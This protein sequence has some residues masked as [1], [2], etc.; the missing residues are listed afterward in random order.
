MNRL[1]HVMFWALVVCSIPALEARAG[2]EPD[3]DGDGLADALEDT[4]GN[5]LF[6]PGETDLHNADTDGGGTGDGLERA[7]G[8]DPL[9]TLDDGDAD[10]D[11]DGLISRVEWVLG[12]ATL[13][14]D[15]DHDGLA[16]GLEVGERG[17]TDPT[18]VTNPLV[19]DTDLDGLL[20]GDEDADRDG[21]VDADESDPNRAD[22]DGGGTSD[23]AERVGGTDPQDPDDDPDGDPDGDGLLNG[24]ERARGTNPRAADTDADGFNDG[25]EVQVSG[26]NPRLADTDGDGLDDAVEDTDRDGHL[27]AN[28]TDPRLADTDGGGSGDGEER[29][30]G[31]NPR[32]GGDDPAGDLDGDSLTA[33]TERA[34]GTDPNDDDTDDDGLND[35]AEVSGGTAPLLADTDA[36]GLVDGLEDA[37]R[38]GRTDVGESDP[39][40]ADS[41][42]GGTP[43]GREVTDST[44]PLE[45]RD[46][47]ERDLDDDGLPAR[48]ELMLGTSPE[49]SDSDDDGVLDG[50]EPAP[51]EDSD[52]DGDVNALDFDSDNDT[53]PDGLELGVDLPEGG[54]DV[55][56]GHFTPDAEPATTTSPIRADTD[57]GGRSDGEEDINGNGRQDPGETSPNRAADDPVGAPDTDADGLS[58]AEERAVGTDPQDA[59]TDDDGLVDGAEAEP[60]VDSDGD[61]A[62]NA[63]DADSDDDG[64][65][66]G[67]EQGVTRRARGTEGERFTPDAEPESRT[68]PLRADTDGDGRTD[69]AEDADRDG[70]QGRDETDPN[71][72]D[73]DGDGLSDGLEFLGDTDGD[74][75][76]DGLDVDSDN[77]GTDDGVE[78]TNQ[79][80]RVDADETDPRRAEGPDPFEPDDDRRPSALADGGAETE[81]DAG[82]GIAE[83]GPDAFDGRGSQPSREPLNGSAPDSDGDGV[84]DDSE[85]SAGLNPFDADSDDD[86]LSDSEEGLDDTDGDGQLDALDV[87][88]DDDGLFDGTEAGRTRPV[89]GTSLAAGRFRAD[90]DPTDQTSPVLAD[91]DGG[92]APDGAEDLN[93]NGRV[94]PGETDPTQANDDSEAP[95][96][97]ANGPAEDPDSLRARGGGGRGCSV[98]APSPTR[99]PLGGA[100]LVALAAVGLRRRRLSVAGAAVL[101]VGLTPRIAAAYDANRF[102]PAAGTQAM[103]AVESAAVGDSLATRFS[104]LYHYARSPLVAEYP[105]GVMVG[106]LLQGLSVVDLTVGMAVFDR[107]ELGIGLPMGLGLS[108]QSGEILEG[109]RAQDPQGGALGDLR[110]VFGVALLPR[111][112]EGVGLAVGLEATAPTGNAS[113]W[114]GAP[115]ATWHP[116]MM[117]DAARGRLLLA[118]NAGWRVRPAEKLLGETVDDALSFAA[119]VRVDVGAGLSLGAE[120][121][122]ELP[123]SETDTSGIAADALGVV[124]WNFQSCF[125]LM[126]GGGRGLGSA[127]GNPTWRALGGL[128]WQCAGAAAP[129]PS[130][131]DQGN[132]VQHAEPA[133]SAPPAP[134]EDRDADGVPNERDACPEVAEDF[135]GFQ[136]HDGCPEPDNDNDRLADENDLCPNAAEDRDGVE[137]DDGCPDTDDDRD[138]ILDLNDRCPREPED[139]DGVED[140]DGCPDVEPT[141]VQAPVTRYGDA[142]IRGASIGL[143]RPIVLTRKGDR[144]PPSVRAQLADVA[145]LLAA[146]P[147]LAHV[148]IEVH[149]DSE[150]SDAANLE[151]TQLRARQILQLLVDLGVSPSRLKADGRGES[152]PIDSNTDP[153]GR[154]ANRR[155]E[156]RLD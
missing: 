145:A 82:S 68:N 110:G 56:A 31:S 53:L 29:R 50:R 26:T 103:T 69:G 38:N 13:G 119:G 58:D 73:T 92:G 1:L 48:A 39:R 22:T 87:D 33:A 42:D 27:D 6:D 70:A 21:A 23:S 44:N 99:S 57:G 137:D 19:E 12:T 86:G 81:A 43:D 140:L 10:P 106:P 126:A 118:A 28:E 62:V 35:G 112:G 111:R 40:R 116:R 139:L 131:P 144:L 97:Q 115:G 41:D 60:R 136:E 127:P 4:D 138:Q 147:D 91:T 74:G 89:R 71:R 93:R 143:A 102:H 77:D 98:A 150:G 55:E 129:V 47:L 124:G 80:G 114:M 142:E 16:D 18:T 149:S 95:G 64:L 45:A 151:K 54:T 11:G 61:G 25:F 152:E 130:A 107:F 52:D 133:P 76:V 128:S 101:G 34:L 125:R 88:S 15:S 5:G 121:F 156:F 51:G 108:G 135:D 123:V 78:D 7:D 100:L 122:G 146:R 120:T 59:D 37:N 8:S 3:S 32:N 65:S 83:E 75:L 72:A 2:G 46:D 148:R 105:D 154:A 20:D 109:D 84:D 94:D 132:R 141:A 155:V 36:D 85:N 14:G 24:E 67:L 153:E 134:L 17:D 9:A 66:D 113:L 117:V 30:L 79:N 104:V 96:N 49:D 63:A 90:A